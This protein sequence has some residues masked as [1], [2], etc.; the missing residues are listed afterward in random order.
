MIKCSRIQKKEILQKVFHMKKWSNQLSSESGVALVMVLI[1]SA[2]A[3]ATMGG[4]IYMTTTGTQISGAQKR[5]KTALEAG[6]G[7]ADITFALI[8][9][10]GDPM[11]TGLNYN[12]FADSVGG[13]NCLTDKLNMPTIDWDAACDD[14]LHIDPAL[15][16]AAVNT[17]DMVVSLGWTPTYTVYSKIVDTVEGNSGGSQGLTKGGVVASNSGEITPVS[18]PYLYSFEV[19][20]QNAAAPAERGKLSVLYQ[21]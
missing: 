5:Y 1:I 10:R 21:Y 4:L 16:P 11:I 9:A 2:I 20:A 18:I 13:V 15:N 17:Y 8:A 3:L 12:I 19:D 7:G 14:T 6:Y